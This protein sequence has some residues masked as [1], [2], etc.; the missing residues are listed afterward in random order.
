M[1]RLKSYGGGG[2]PTQPQIKNNNEWLKQEVNKLG[3]KH[4]IIVDLS[5]QKGFDMYDKKDVY[6]VKFSL[7]DTDWLIGYDRWGFNCDKGP[8]EADQM[9]GLEMLKEIK[10]VVERRKESNHG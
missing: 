4:A 9:H 5:G 3:A 7:A 2:G 6:V 10:A 1:F 8:V